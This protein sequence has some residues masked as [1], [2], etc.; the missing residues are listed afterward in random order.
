MKPQSQISRQFG[1]HRRAEM[2]ARVRPIHPATD[3]AFRTTGGNFGVANNQLRYPATPFH[4]L[5]QDFLAE[6]MKREYLKEAFFFLIIVGLSAWPIASMM[7]AL[8]LLK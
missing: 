8:S 1:A 7:S 2:P 4:H 5:S 3:F 6:E